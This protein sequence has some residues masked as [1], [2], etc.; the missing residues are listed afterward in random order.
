MTVAET[1]AAATRRLAVAGSDTAR[2]DARVLLRHVTGWTEVQLITRD[3]DPLGGHAPAYEALVRRREDGEPVAYLIGEKE[4]HSLRFEVGP[5]V[6]VPRPETEGVVEAA[7]A[8]L[9][10]RRDGP[11]IVDVGT[12][13]GAIAVAIRHALGDRRATMLA[14]DCSAGA[15]AMAV[16]NARRLLGGRR[17]DAIHFVRGDLTTAIRPG[18]VDLVVAN[19]PYLTPDDL[20]LAPR[21]LGFEPEGA[22]AGG[23]ADGLD[24]VRRLLAD[25]RRVLRAGGRVL[26][27]IGSAQEISTR[28]VAR[29]LGFGDAEVL[30]DLEGRPRVLRADTA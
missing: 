2:L 8:F 7:L 15:L 9:A 16:G 29:G 6:L 11:T 22:L 3:R 25:A 4:F 23:G 19:P 24:V 26:C 17:G 13:S 28:E 21:E 1:L 5:A 14:I 27:E 10:D 20:R 30:R 12:G 18:A